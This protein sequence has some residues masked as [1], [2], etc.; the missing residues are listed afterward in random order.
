MKKGKRKI[1][2]ELDT[3][4]DSVILAGIRMSNR[5]IAGKTGLTSGQITYRLH[6]YKKETGMT[7]TVRQG[8]NLSNPLVQRILRDHRGI[9]ELEFQ[10]KFLARVVHP[11]PVIVQGPRPRPVTVDEAVRK[12]KRQKAGWL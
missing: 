10:R 12:L 5:E 4:Q 2:M 3:F 9:M 11:T 8:W 1:L 6:T 7:H